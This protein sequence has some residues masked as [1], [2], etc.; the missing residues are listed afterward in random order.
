MSKY[1]CGSVTLSSKS[2]TYNDAEAS[3]AEGLA[4]EGV[5]LETAAIVF[6]YFFRID[7]T[8]VFLSDQTDLPSQ[9]TSYVI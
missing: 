6:I 2:P 1:T 7:P 5:A 3:G 9:D 8:L 4:P